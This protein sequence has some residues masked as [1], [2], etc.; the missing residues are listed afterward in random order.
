MPNHEGA[1]PPLRATAYRRA[2]RGWMTRL[3]WTWKPVSL[4]DVGRSSLTS[5]G[6]SNAD[7]HVRGRNGRYSRLC[8]GQASAALSAADKTFVNEAASG[9]LAEV[10]LGQLAQQ[11]ASSPQVKQFGQ[12]M[13]DDHTKANQEL[14]AIAETE[15]LTLPTQPEKY[16]A[17]IEHM[18]QDHEKDV[19]AFRKEARSRQDPAVEGFAQKYL[20]VL[21][22]HLQ[23]A[24][25]L[26]KG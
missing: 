8:A 21:E 26:N 7:D 14:Q 18:V 10:Q 20:P 25:A 6:R 2:I 15:N 23:M 11:K 17:Y 4:E 9:G 13:M 5:R 16:R 3:R 12:R 19:A 22:Q 1:R 24:K